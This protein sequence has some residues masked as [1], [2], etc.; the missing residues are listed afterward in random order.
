MPFQH[1]LVATDFSEC[2]KRALDLGI[3][4]AQKFDAQLTVAHIWEVPTYSYGPGMYV[5]GDW[6]TPIEAAAQARLDETVEDLKARFPNAKSLLRTGAPWD[7][8]LA[9]AQSVHADLI[10]MG[11]HGRRGLNRALIG[12]VA[13]RVVRLSA[14]PVLT[15]HSS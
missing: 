2:S 4:L 11:T 7:E 12:S 8:I 9:A 13:E 14:V 1:V 15:T 10:V 6:L 3:E 5:P